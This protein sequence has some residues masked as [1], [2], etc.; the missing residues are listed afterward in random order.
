MAG[1]SPDECKL[2]KETREHIPAGAVFSS[3]RE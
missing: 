2:L 3:E 1:R